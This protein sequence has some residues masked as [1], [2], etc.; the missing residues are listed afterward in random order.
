[1]RLRE[2]VVYTRF[3]S[4]LSTHELAL[5]ELVFRVLG[6]LIRL[7]TPAQDPLRLE[8]LVL[9]RPHGSPI[10]HAHQKLVLNGA[11]IPELH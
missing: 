5:S 2:V 10:E 8:R 9:S 1:M 3:C 4:L 7:R 11:W 6:S